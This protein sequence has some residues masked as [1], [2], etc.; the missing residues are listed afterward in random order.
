MAEH[1]SKNDTTWYERHGRLADGCL[2]NESGWGHMP[3]QSFICSKLLAPSQL[4]A[5]CNNEICNQ[6]LSCNP[7]R[8]TMQPM[9]VAVMQ[10]QTRQPTMHRAS[11][12]SLPSGPT[13][14][15]CRCLPVYP[16][17]IST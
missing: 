11:L 7:T 12:S 5:S 4:P 8:Q 2:L 17:H 3:T 14:P 6:G 15:R 9:Q 10:D 13:K 1:V 16:K